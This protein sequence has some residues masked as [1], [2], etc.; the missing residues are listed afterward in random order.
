MA[1]LLLHLSELVLA[2]PADDEHIPTDLMKSL[3]SQRAS[4]PGTL[5]ITESN[6][7]SKKN[8]DLRNMPGLS[9]RKQTAAWKTIVEEI[10][11]RA[12][13][14][15]A[16][17]RVINGEMVEKEGADMRSTSTLA[18]ETGFLQASKNV[19][20][21]S[22]EGVELLGENGDFIDT[23][24]NG[25]PIKFT[26][27]MK[28]VDSLGIA[29]IHLNEL[30]FA[31]QNGVRENERLGFA[32]N[33]FRGPILVE[34]GYTSKLAQKLVDERHPDKD[35]VRM[36]GRYSTSNPDLVFSMDIDIS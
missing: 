7:T 16:Q 18:L 33:A 13:F 6:L 36:F 19:V 3:F 2:T 9:T 15:F 31:D 5:L 24:F 8:D 32:Y 10:H 21:A 1:L 35:I 27:V 23:L 12:S 30:H 34:G 25:I 26:N 29:Y 14:I 28:R 11:L 4:V 17:L 22:F 20:G